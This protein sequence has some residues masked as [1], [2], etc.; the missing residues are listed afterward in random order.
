MLSALNKSV[1]VIELDMQGRVITANA[2]L[3]SVVGYTLDEIR[4]MPH[5]RFVEPSYRDSPE[6]AAF[7]RK[8]RAG[9][10][11][12][13]RYKRVGKDGRE[14]WIEATYNPIF[15]R[16]GRP[17]K[18]V[19]FATDITRQMI[20]EADL[21]GQV[22]AI[23]MSQATVTFDLD[24]MILD[25]NENFLAAM[26]YTLAEVR[27]QHHRLFVQPSERDSEE[28]ATFW[29]R[30]RAG[31]YQAA[32]Y[33]RLG[34]GGREVWILASY[35]PV[36]DPSGRPYKVVKL[37]TDITAQVQLSTERQKS[38]LARQASEERL[39]LALDAGRL[40]TWDWNIPTGDVAWSEQ[41]YTL[42]GYPIGGVTPSYA[43]WANR[44]HPEDIAE[45]EAKLQH[46]MQ[47]RTAYS[48]EFRFFH[49]DGTT[50]WCEAQGRFEYDASGTPIRMVGIM[51][52]VTDRKRVE[53]A[54]L[55]AKDEAEAA[56]HAKSN[57]LAAMSHEI[58][59]PLNGILGYADL[60]ME[61]G[62]LTAHQHQQLSRVHSAGTALLTV[63]NDILDFSQIEAGKIT[64][65]VR[66][67]SLR[68][69]LDTSISIVQPLSD[70]KRLALS[71]DMGRDVPD[72]LLGDQDRLRQVLLNLLNNAIKFTP[73]GAVT[74][75]V[76]LVR[77]S[78]R[79]AQIRFAV[80]DTGIGIPPSKLQ[81]LF[82]RF[83][84][85]DSSIR[86]EFGGTGLGLAI[87]KN[88]VGLMGGEIGVESEPRSGSTFWFQIRLHKAEPEL[89]EAQRRREIH[90]ASRRSRVLLVEDNEINQEIAK[91]V[92]EN[93]GHEV[94]IAGDGAQA[95]MLVQQ[96][97]F[98]LVLM[99]V[100]MPT[101]DGMTAT[102]VIRGLKAPCRDVPI[103]A[104]TANVLPQHVAEF[105]EA[106][107]EGFVGK[108][109][110]KAD[111]LNAISRWSRANRAPSVDQDGP[112]AHAAA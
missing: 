24:G 3:L 71:L 111:L 96:R 79:D 98:D 2:N 66:P 25:A 100:Q 58:R 59:T 42:L 29:A 27:G 107:M 18:I 13:G 72:R 61:D 46:A 16:K 77:E 30:L 75:N 92:L 86:R 108:P 9:E 1:G 67:F 68:A 106:G 102:R 103:V 93:A 23:R 26:G 112:T 4:G 80:R 8:L 57:F 94:T 60:L 5:S 76:S 73:S 11:D 15:D 55:L 65:D 38:E 44:V 36:L 69:L 83:S 35:Y 28:Y 51:R 49:P 12:A 88:L 39:R 14:I 97:D 70:R 37:A 78:A 45:T 87:S 43:A 74:L 40:A 33:K 10:F 99:D 82:Q 31:Q 109:F 81:H 64:L 7:W 41:H 95:V 19:K 22:N 50:V 48:H 20:E 90:E 62:G 89:P 6:Y 110:K 85:I 101:M 34:K 47:S 84:Q 52:D 104:L 105:T 17:Y 32:Q 63:V 56:S 21:K 54:L 53:A 91:A